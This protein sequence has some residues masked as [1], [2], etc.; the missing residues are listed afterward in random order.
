PPPPPTFTPA[1]PPPSPRKA[2]PLPLLL[3]FPWPSREGG[4]EEA[5]SGDP[6]WR[7]GDCHE[8]SAAPESR[9][10]SPPSPSP[11]P[12]GRRLVDAVPRSPASRTPPP[13]PWGSRLRG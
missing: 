12:A 6:V 4:L 2:G 7:E 5:A 8:Q 1:P 9:R 10:L 3:P 11:P 13:P